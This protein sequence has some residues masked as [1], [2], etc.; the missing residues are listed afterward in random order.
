MHDDRVDVATGGGLAPAA[1]RHKSRT[2]GRPMVAPTNTRTLASLRE[3]GG[4]CEANDGRSLR[5]IVCFASL[6]IGT[7]LLGCHGRM[8]SAPT[9][10]TMRQKSRFVG[11]GAPIGSALGVSRRPV[12]SPFGRSPAIAGER[13]WRRARGR[14]RRAVCAPHISRA[15]A[16][17]KGAN[18][19]SGVCSMENCI[20]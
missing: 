17:S 11:D 18:L 12:G 5:D 9:T 7:T 15:Y 13:E 2:S 16:T 14:P 4:I 19:P 3:G 10:H 6:Y 20:K 8:I 1:P